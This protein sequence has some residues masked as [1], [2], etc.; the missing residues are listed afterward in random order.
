MTNGYR[1]ALVFNI[2][3]NF[4]VQLWHLALGKER[5][6]FQLEPLTHY[7]H[8]LPMP[9]P[10]TTPTQVHPA[11]DSMVRDWGK[12]LWSAFQDHNYSLVHEQLFKEFKKLRDE[13]QTLHINKLSMVD[14][15]APIYDHIASQG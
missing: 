2:V 4:N 6:F 9:K 13:V 3:F 11:Y 7:I 10:K 14:Y 12:R 15:V 8:H 1:R 5:F